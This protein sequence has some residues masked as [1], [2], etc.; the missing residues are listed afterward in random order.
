M[1]AFA[2]WLAWPRGVTPTPLSLL[3]TSSDAASLASSSDLHPV[4]VVDVDW[5]A[6]GDVA[7]KAGVGAALPRGCVGSLFYPAA[8][9]GAAPPP[10]W[11]GGFAYTYGE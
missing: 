8:G 11:A 3:E 5:H 10:R 6:G 7:G 4:G 2:S 1:A 9:P